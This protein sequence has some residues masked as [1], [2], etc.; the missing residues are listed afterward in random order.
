MC[1]HTGRSNL[2]Q[3]LSDTERKYVDA[4]TIQMLLTRI[5]TTS[6]GS[7][8]RQPLKTR[9]WVIDR[10]RMYKLLAQANRYS[11]DDSEASEVIGEEEEKNE[12]TF[13]YVLS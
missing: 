1:S 8:L 6:R 7:T 4:T 5:T 3:D 9:T 13:N 2:A 12:L 11:W 10:C